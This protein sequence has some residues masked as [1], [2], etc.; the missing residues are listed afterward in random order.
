MLRRRPLPIRPRR[1][2][3]WRR[4]GAAINA[5]TPTTVKHYPYRALRWGRAIPS[6]PSR[7][8]EA[9]SA[10]SKENESSPAAIE[11]ECDPPFRGRV[12]PNYLGDRITELLCGV[13]HRRASFEV[14]SPSSMSVV[15]QEHKSL[16][17]DR[18][19]ELHVRGPTRIRAHLSRSSKERPRSSLIL[20][21][22]RGGT[23]LP[24]GV[25]RERLVKQRHTCRFCGEG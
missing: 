2:P 17:R 23:K 6:F 19:T 5:E 18:I 7:L 1:R 13:E 4:H 16:L 21:S 9:P 11:Q 15:Q 20:I 22:P 10:S 25:Q 14:E 24:V 12:L 8:S 3:R